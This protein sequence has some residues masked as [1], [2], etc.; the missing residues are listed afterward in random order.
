VLGGLAR[1]P[2]EVTGAEAI[3]TSFPDFVPLMNALGAA[4]EEVEGP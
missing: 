3:A 1:R 4:L 2:V